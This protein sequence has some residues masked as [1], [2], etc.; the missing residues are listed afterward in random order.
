MGVHMVAI[1]SPICKRSW[2]CLGARICR[3]RFWHLLMGSAHPPPP[4]PFLC[5]LVHAL[6]CEQSLPRFLKGA[7]HLRR[8]RSS[9]QGAFPSVPLSA[10]PPLHRSCHCISIAT[11]T[12]NKMIVSASTPLKE[13]SNA[14]EVVQIG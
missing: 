1:C 12:R 2:S 11:S 3:C 6:C 4:P 10:Q 7:V 14:L 8:R 5:R 13:L 9:P